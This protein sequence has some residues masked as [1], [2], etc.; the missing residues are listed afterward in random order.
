MVLGGA[1]V[2][3]AVTGVIGAL[4]GKGFLILLAVL[5]FAY[6]YGLGGALN[7]LP[8]YVWIVAILVTILILLK[9]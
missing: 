3:A 1:I 5:I 4:T 2:I 8:I 9:K 6:S 7:G